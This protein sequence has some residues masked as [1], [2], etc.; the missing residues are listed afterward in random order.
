MNTFVPKL[1]SAFLALFFALQLAL[2]SGLIAPDRAMAQ[3][4]K[5]IVFQGFWWDFKNNNYPQGW[6]NYLIDLAPRLREMG[7]TAIWVPVN[8]KNENPLSVGYSP[9]DHYDLGDKYQKSNLKTPFGDKDEFLRMVAV[10]HANGIEVV[11]DIVLNHMDRAGSASG[12]GG[13]DPAAT[14]FYNSISGLPADP[15]GGA[16]TFRYTS[17]G[18]PAQDESAADYLSRQGRW[19]KNWQNFYP[20][21]SDRRFTGDDLTRTTFGPDIAFNDGSVGQSSNA[22]YN[23]VQAQTYMRTEA[24]A[25][26]TWMKKQ[27]GIDGY[28]LDAV[29]HF[30]AAVA[31]DMLFNM[32]NNAGFASGTS[33]M[34]AVAEWVGGKAEVDA[35]VDAVQD[36]A[37]TFDFA[38][39]GFSNTPGLVAMVYG[40]GGYDMSNLPSTQQDRRFRTFPFV[41]NHDTFRPP[42]SANGNYPTNPNGSQQRWTSG[43]ELAPNIDPREP[44]L[45]AAYAVMMAMDGNP[46][47]FFEDLFDVGTTGKRFTHKPNDTTNLPTKSDI[48][49]LIACHSKL[50]WKGGDY[51]VRHQ[52]PDYLIIERA[53]KAIIGATDNFTTWQAQWIDTRFAPGTRLIDYGSSSPASDVRTV[54]ADGRVQISTPPCNGTARRRGYSVWGP[55]GININAPISPL[56]LPTAQEWELENDLGDSHPRSLGQ[57]GRLPSQSLAWRTAGKVYPAG[58]SVLKVE[59]FVIDPTAELELQIADACGN[60]LGSQIGRGN[61][62]FNFTVATVGWYQ[63][64]VRNTSLAN[65]GQKLFIKATYTAPRFVDGFATPSFVPTVANLGPDTE[66]CGGTR[67]DAATGSGFSYLWADSAGNSLGSNFFYIPTR[68]G[69]IY[70]TK[71]NT[72]SGCVA[73][74]TLK[75]LRYNPQPAFPF[76]VQSGDSLRLVPEAGIRYQWR[77]A[78]VD[79]PGATGPSYRPAASGAYSVVGT[80]AQGCKRTGN[81]INY[82]LSNFDRLE[83]TIT[84][85]PNPATAGGSTLTLGNLS[86]SRATYTL[87]T[88]QGKAIQS[89]TLSLSQGA[90]QATI[91]IAALPAGLYLVKIQTT[92]GSQ[93]IRLL[94]GN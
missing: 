82:I 72:A 35:Y 77:L 45:A 19:P 85:A 78:G 32:Q 11:Q 91:S 46:G 50:D 51:L 37:G 43:S 7:I 71:T 12:A 8:I 27:T 23:P 21:P 28:R 34:L 63:I 47:I 57:G 88:L 17:F 69:S 61:Q 60:S 16:K 24:R 15:T 68:A 39:H 48:R 76:I 33:E 84:L 75:I 52:A 31:E 83:G 56:P 67:L 65:N 64:R 92:T 10:M 6:A 80:S 44:R 5:R 4:R 73:R 41:N 22:T 58:G 55:I 86:G 62:V 79:I 25:W 59:S 2:F 26:M 93:T 18:G 87:L 81:G 70:L 90:A 74:D 30:P 49:N 13:Q 38:L 36:R 89:K 14:A 53:G 54:A 3:N 42:G 94:V 66:I 40:Q 9:F 29:K 20:N 1:N